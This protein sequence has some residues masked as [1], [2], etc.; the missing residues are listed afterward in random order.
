M[1]KRKSG[2]C[3]QQKNIENPWT[4]LEKDANG[5][6]KELYIRHLR[7]DDD[8]LAGEDDSQHEDR[9]GEQQ[10]QVTNGKDT[11]ANGKRNKIGIF[12]GKS[13]SYQKKVK[14]NQFRKRI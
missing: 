2:E 1:S 7:E 3:D 8:K 10:E 9:N 13:Y 12:Q 14:A 6:V 11:E 4:I 5:L